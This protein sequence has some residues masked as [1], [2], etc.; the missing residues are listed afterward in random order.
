MHLLEIRKSAT[1]EYVKGMPA[2]VEQGLDISVHADRIAEDEGTTGGG[3]VRAVAARRLALAVIQVQQPLPAHDLEIISQ[4][5][6]Y[7][8]ENRARFFFQLG[9]GRKRLEGRPTAHIHVNI[10]AS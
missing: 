8:L 5:G 7:A 9:D 4:R 6:V 1:L 3:E 10:P 2:L